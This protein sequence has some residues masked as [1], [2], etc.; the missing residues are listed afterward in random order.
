MGE[1]MTVV[2]KTLEEAESLDRMIDA[3]D[4]DIVQL[5][6]ANEKFLA[7][8]SEKT[9]W[10]KYEELLGKERVVNERLFL[11][12]QQYKSDVA[13]MQEGLKNTYKDYNKGNG[14]LGHNEFLKSGGTKLNFD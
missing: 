11:D 2:R 10:K 9:S 14:I 3:K 7:V 1:Y 13:V 4:L 8:N 12:L 5:K 6:K